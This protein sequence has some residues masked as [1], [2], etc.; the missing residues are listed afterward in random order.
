MFKNPL[1]VF[2]LHPCLECVCVEECNQSMFNLRCSAVTG[3]NQKDVCSLG[4]I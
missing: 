3:D 2:S 4:N 1:L